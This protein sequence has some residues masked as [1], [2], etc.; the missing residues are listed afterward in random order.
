VPL[1]PQLCRRLSR[2][3][4]LGAILAVPATLVGA[5]TLR[6]DRAAGGYA[7]LLVSTDR[8]REDR[9]IVG[10]IETLAGRSVHMLRGTNLLAVRVPRRDAPALRRRLAQ[11]RG[12]RFVERNHVV[13]RVATAHVAQAIPN[14][15]LWRNQWGA[16]LIGAPAAWK[17]TRGS[18][19]VVIAMLDTGVDLSQ[20]DL[21]Q[22]LVP[23]FDVVNWDDDPSDDNGHGTRTA[24]IVGARAD[25]GVGISGV[26]P[27]CSIMPVKVVGANGSATGLEVASGIRWA[28]EHGAAIISLSL[29]GT[30]SDVVAA[31]V[32]YAESKGVI[33]VAAAGNN[34]SSQPFYPAADPGVLSVAGTQT[35]DQLYPWSNRGSWVSV[36]AP[37]CDITTFRDGE[38]GRFCGTSASTPVVAGLAGLA[39]SYSPSSS[40][41]A[42]ER[43]IL[44]TVRPVAGIAGGRV[45]AVG[46]LKA[47]GATFRPKRV[48]RTLTSAKR[49]R[50]ARS[51]ASTALRAR[52]SRRAL[53]LHW[54]LPLAVER[55]RVV[56]TLH[57]PKARACSLSLRSGDGARRVSTRLRGPTSL[58]AKVAAGR[59]RLDVRCNLRQ[60]QP[61]SLT[62]R[63]H[64]AKASPRSHSRPAAAGRGGSSVPVTI[65][66]KPV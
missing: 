16:A 58:V 46:T 10:R 24:G 29:G 11:I 45:D 34:A 64:F 15:P 63:A 59:Y 6:P 12:V 27:R 48:S 66:L 21:Q 28:T 33:V 36:A 22:A 60:P 4:L 20:P 39:L 1:P 23:G 37:G 51:T 7:R 35:G 14:D 50:S 8:P 44:S 41:D 2:L 18:P 55:G 30:Q 43:A 31:A 52:V 3:A 42:I 61:A 26:C 5:T 13:M 9:A 19:R 40:A 62:V 38:F 47:L 49:G 17:V 54:H 57:S 56:A 65:H 53:R 32:H 25:N